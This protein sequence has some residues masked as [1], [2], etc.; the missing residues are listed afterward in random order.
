M[1]A[2][3]KLAVSFAMVNRWD[4]RD[5]EPSQIAVNAIKNLCGEH[6]KLE[7]TSI[8]ISNEAVI[9]YHGSKSGLHGPIV[10]G[11]WDLCDFG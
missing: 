2:A 6:N 10:P 5:C 7:G 3:E 11:S 8:I 4:K 1:C 9:L